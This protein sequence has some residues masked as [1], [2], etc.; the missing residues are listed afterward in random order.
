VR[1]SLYLEEQLPVIAGLVVGTAFILLVGITF[2]FPVTFS[3]SDTAPGALPDTIKIIRITSYELQQKYPVLKNGQD[4][5]DNQRQSGIREP[6]PFSTYIPILQANQM[7]K[8][9]PFTELSHSD[10]NFGGYYLVIDVGSDKQNGSKIVDAGE[11]L[12]VISLNY[13]KLP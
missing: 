3:M 7:K 11:K 1:D 5:L 8:E 9:L 2:Y 10:Q 12:Y 4:F 13:L 6:I